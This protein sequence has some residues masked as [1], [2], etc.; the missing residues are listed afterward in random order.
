M[1]KEVLFLRHKLQK[2]LLAREGIPKEDEMR[3]MSDFIVKLENMP[4]LE[5]SI[6]RSTKINK[7]LKAILKL[8]SIPKEAEFNFRPRSQTLL[9]K[10]NQVLAASEGGAAAA[11]A[12]NG[13]NGDDK[14]ASAA[15][16]ESNGVKDAEKP[17]EAEK[18]KTEKAEK[19][20]K[21]SPAVAEEAK[22][23]KEATDKPADEVNC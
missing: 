8:S 15:P 2:G 21:A 22:A 7:V 23:E 12:A 9:D 20:E 4:D 18:E 11:P 3:N 1:Q 16:A 19:A 14:E 5:A 13:V 6:I 17:Q 10:W